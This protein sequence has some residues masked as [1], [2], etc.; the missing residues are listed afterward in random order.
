M[1]KIILLLSL[2][3]TFSF[4]SYCQLFSED[5]TNATTNWQSTWDVVNQDGGG[6]VA[7]WFQFGNVMGSFSNDGSQYDPD[8]YAVTP[9]IDVTGATGLSLDYQAGG[10]FAGFSDEVFTVYASTGNVVPDDFL[11][12][13]MN[14][15]TTI[16]SD[17][18]LANFPAADGA[19]ADFNFDLSSLDGETAIYI[20]FR[21]HNTPINQSMLQIDNIV[22]T[23]TVLGIDDAIF[24]GFNYFVNAGN[25]LHLSSSNKNL[26]HVSIYNLLGQEVVTRKLNSTHATIDLSSLHSGVYITKVTIDGIAKAFKIVKK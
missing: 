8:H 12:P 18:D 6:G 7:V 15:V 10:Q 22:L 11:T 5:F 9:L 21:H 19:L 2:S 14:G 4:N 24:S 3:L 13:A 1:K 16:S 20:A 26:S 17:I 23:G 25:V